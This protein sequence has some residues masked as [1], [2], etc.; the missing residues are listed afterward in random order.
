MELADQLRA[1]SD[2]AEDVA[3]PFVCV[4][5][6]RCRVRV[7]ELLAAF[8]AALGVLLLLGEFFAALRGS[9]RGATFAERTARSESLADIGAG[10]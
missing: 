3:A 1:C 5:L 8:I 7:I 9:D 6:E 4:L 10:H 2:H